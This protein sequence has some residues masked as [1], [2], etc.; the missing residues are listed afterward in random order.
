MSDVKISPYSRMRAAITQVL[1]AHQA[2]VDDIQSHAQR[3]EAELDAMRK[4]AEIKARVNE[5]IARQ[6]G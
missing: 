4:D 6:N 1:S 2:I 5:G 3:R